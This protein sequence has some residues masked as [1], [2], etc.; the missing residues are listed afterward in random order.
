LQLFFLDDYDD[1]G[2]YQTRKFSVEEEGRGKGAI[3]RGNMYQTSAN[4]RATQHDTS[5]TDIDILHTTFDCLPT[6]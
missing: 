5:F 6:F 3:H 1:K 4:D 2:H